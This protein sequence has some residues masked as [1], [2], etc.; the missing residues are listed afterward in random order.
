MAM[1]RCGQTQLK[2]G[3]GYHFPVGAYVEYIG[4]IDNSI[5]DKLV[6]DL[7]AAANDIIKEQAAESVWSKICTYEEASKVLKDG[8][9][10]Y[11]PA[12]QEL[13]VVK[14]SEEDSGCPCGG[15]HV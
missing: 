13:R 7:T 8:V 11:I 3:K 10:P 2:P 6:Q 15:T 9:P 5:K 12:G 4:N 14:L 1:Q